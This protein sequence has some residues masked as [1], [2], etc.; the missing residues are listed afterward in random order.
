MS[1]DLVAKLGVDSSDWDSGF[2]KASS[3]ASSFASGFT[4]LLGPLVG[5]IGGIWGAASS[6]TA[7][8]ESL[9]AQ[10]KLSAVILATGGA[11]GLT[12]AE[13]ADFSAEMQTLTN[14]EDDAT[15]AAAATLAAFTNI[16]GQ[17]FTDTIES[18]MDLTTIIGGDLQGNVK[19]LGKALNDPAVSF[20]K[21]AKAGVTF[22][23]SQKK[24]IAT[25]QQSGDL[26]GAQSAL[27]EGIQDKFGGAAMAVADPWK[28][29]QNTLGDVMENIGSMILPTINVISTTVR[30][31]LGPV[32]A[33][34]DAFK[35][36]GIETAVTL[37]PIIDLIAATASALVTNLGAGIQAATFGFNALLSV[38]GL[39]GTTLNDFVIEATVIMSHIGEL[40]SLSMDIWTLYFVQVA[41]D[42]MH[43]FT[44][45]IPA[46]VSWFA[47]NFQNIFVTLA[48]NE[49]TL[50]ENM[51]TNIKS[52]WTAILAFLQGQP[53]KFNWTP[54]TDGFINTIEKLPDIPPRAIGE[55]ESGLMKSIDSAT[56]ALGESMNNQREKLAK[57][58]GETRKTLTAQLDTNSKVPGNV[59]PDD[60]DAT[61]AKKE[62]KAKESDNKASL[63]GSAEAAKAI[64]SGFN[65]NKMEEIAG[66]TL[67]VSQEQLTESQKQTA[68]LEKSPDDEGSDF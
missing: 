61:H 63:I 59:V 64:F 28:Q 1:S 15:T 40:I 12:T 43:L 26:I 45:T 68:L 66:K 35:N 4:G 65:N 38:I 60:A 41:A 7:F 37:Y 25:M 33:A 46:Y 21:L 49:L 48:S 47:D 42:A 57:E 18:A 50:F 32:V 51:G 39:G 9:E 19:L 31:M 24:Q 5:A 62:K 53:L 16:R 54:L 3:T 58:M 27:L 67:E 36:F 10:R 34:G 22:T 52:A 29:L 13:I 44:E 30:M 6:V 14:F 17:T 20:G 11:A 55:L 8:K 23:D 56:D 2:K